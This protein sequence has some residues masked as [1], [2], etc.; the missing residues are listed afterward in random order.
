MHRL[1]TDNK[2]FR[3]T[4]DLARRLKRFLKFPLLHGRARSAAVPFRSKRQRTDWIAGVVAPSACRW[5]ENSLSPLEKAGPGWLAILRRSGAH[6]GHR[7][8][9]S[10]ADSPAQC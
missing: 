5:K 9:T 2:E 10:G 4:R 6:S 8:P 1:G 7:E 3:L